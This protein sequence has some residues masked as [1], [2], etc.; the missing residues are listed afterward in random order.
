VVLCALFA[1]G[2]AA[3]AQDPRWPA[4]PDETPKRMP[5]GRLQSEVILKQDHKDNL[6]DLDRM[7]EL[8]EAIREDLDKNDRHVLSL[9]SLK[10]LEEIERLSRRVRSRMRKH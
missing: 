5:D 4:R 10:S 2:L 3:L 6:A 8:L 7:K 1:S 9:K